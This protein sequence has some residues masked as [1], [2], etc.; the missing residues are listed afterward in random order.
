MLCLS[1]FELYSRWVPLIKARLQYLQRGYK[2]SEAT[3][4]VPCIAS[5]V[6][7]FQA[8]LLD[9]LFKFFVRIIKFT[10]P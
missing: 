9:S 7:V 6:A 8:D 2:A 1:G 5:I 4:P 10:F 3:S